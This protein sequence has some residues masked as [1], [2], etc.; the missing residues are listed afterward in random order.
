M[1]RTKE[2]VDDERKADKWWVHSITPATP[3]LY[4]I[5]AYMKQEEPA[6][7]IRLVLF[8]AVVESNDCTGPKSDMAVLQK[9]VPVFT[10]WNCTEV[11]V[12]IDH[13]PDQSIMGYA[14][15]AQLFSPDASDVDHCRISD[16]LE[17]VRMHL[18]AHSKKS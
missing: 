17:S 4:A 9:I 8:W 5:R 14:S 10:S 1:S 18:K 2:Y 13:M 12:D 7:E 6:V 11:G 16:W 15:R 3:E